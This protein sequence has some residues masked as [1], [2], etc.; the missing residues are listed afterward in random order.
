MKKANPWFI[1]LV[2]LIVSSCGP[3]I[4]QS[5]GFDEAKN[6]HKLVAILPAEVSINLRPNEMKNTSKERIMQMEEETS[7]AI[8][9]KMYSWFLRRSGKKKYTVQFQD[10][11]RTNSLLKQN[12]ISYSDLPLRGKEELAK[13]LGV[14]AVISTRVSMKKPMSEGAALAVGLV[15]GAWGSTNDVQTSIN[16]HEGQKGDLI[17]KYD[18]DAQGSVGSSTDRLVNALMRNASKKF[19]Y[20][21]R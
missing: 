6:K 21:D 3:K 13:L 9:D 1:F 18:Y 20:N 15:F 2:S 8:Q 7:N 17:W 12:S 10:I 19:P 14:D 4:Y 16:I 5:P 11:S